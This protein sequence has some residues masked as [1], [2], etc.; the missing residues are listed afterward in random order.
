MTKR[1][2]GIF[3]KFV[4]ESN[5]GDGK[6]NSLSGTPEYLHSVDNIIY[7]TKKLFQVNC[8]HYICDVY[9]ELS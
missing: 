2:F 8:L 1:G 5:V 7:L 4:T 6:E 9:F 3:Q